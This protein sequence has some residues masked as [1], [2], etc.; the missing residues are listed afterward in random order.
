[1]PHVIVTKHIVY[2]IILVLVV[3]IDTKTAEI[4]FGNPRTR[5]LIAISIGT[6]V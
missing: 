1:M 4:K 6:V 5:R 2:E 3:W